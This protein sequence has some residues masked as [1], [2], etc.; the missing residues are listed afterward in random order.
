MGF[1]ATGIKGFGTVS[2]CGRILLPIPAIGTIILIRVFYSFIIYF[3]P[4][5]PNPPAPLSL[6]WRDSVGAHSA[7]S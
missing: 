7:F 2:V 5:D 3:V 1:P 4:V 6:S